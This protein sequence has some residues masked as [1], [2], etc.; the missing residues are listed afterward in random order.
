M[1]N[2][3]DLTKLGERSFEHLANFLAL[4]VL[5]AGHTGFGPGADGGRDGFFEGEAAYPSDVNRW[6]GRWYI[7]SKYHR[8][9]LSKD[10]QKW[11]LAKIKEEID[12]FENPRTKRSW[13]DNW[14]IVTNI[15]PSGTPETG[16]FDKA[17][18]LV[19][20]S[21]N[22]LAERFHIWGG[23]KVIQLLVLH[24]EV[25]D[26]YSHFLTPGHV[27]TRLY[28][29]L[30][31]V[32]ASTRSI[33]RHF[34]VTNFNEQQFTKLEQAGSTIDTRPGIHRLFTDLPF[35]CRQA[36]VQ[37][38]SLEYL[39][40]AA[41]QNHR[42]ESRISDLPLWLPWRKNPR[43]ARVWFIKGGPGQGKSTLTQYLAQI[44]RACLMLGPDAPLAT[45]QQLETAREIREVATKYDSWPLAPRIPVYVE[46][47]DFAKWFGER[48]SDRPRGIFTFLA[49]RLSA[50]IQQ[51]VHV[52]T[53]KRA[54]SE[55]RWLFVF[56]G[57]DEVPSDVKDNVAGE[58]IAFIDDQLIELGADAFFVCTSRPQGYSGQFSSL[59]AAETELSPLNT[60]QA[61]TC[62]AP[63][64]RIDRDEVE[65]AQNFETLRE[66]LQSPSIAE[67]MTT[68]LQAH[69][70]AVVVRD[71]GRPPDRKWRLFGSTE[72]ALNDILASVAGTDS[73]SWLIEVLADTLLE[74]SESE[75][76]G[77]AYVLCLLVPE[78]HSRL[79]EIE[80]GILAKS[81]EYRGC[82]FQMLAKKPEQYDPDEIL[83]T[84]HLWVGKLIFRTLASPD[85][86]RLDPEGVEAAFVV[87]A[88]LKDEIP[89]AAHSAGIDAALAEFML[90]L[91]INNRSF[92][93]GSDVDFCGAVRFAYSTPN[94]N[95]D[96]S[97]WSDDLGIAISTAPGIF[98]VI[99]ATFAI[100]SGNRSIDSISRLADIST[101][102]RALPDAWSAYLPN[103]ILSPKESSQVLSKPTATSPKLTWDFKP[104]YTTAMMSA[105]NEKSA[106]YK[107]LLRD[108]PKIGLRIFSLAFRR[109]ASPQRSWQAF[110]SYLETAEGAGLLA[111]I[112]PDNTDWL[113]G[114]V[115]LWGL[116]LKICGPSREIRTA[117]LNAASLSSEQHLYGDIHPFILDL[118]DEE[119]LIGPILSA[120]YANRR[121]SHFS[122][123]SPTVHDRVQQY[124]PNLAPLLALAQERNQ[125]KDLQAAASMMC[126]LHPLCPADLGE[127][128]IK[129]ILAGYDPH[130]SHNYL[131][132]AAFALEDPIVENR[133]D[134]IRAMGSLLRM[135]NSDLRGRLSLDSIFEEWR[136]RSRAPVTRLGLSNF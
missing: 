47:K 108:H 106:D 55:A 13:P 111:A 33:I 97:N 68:P 104:G 134:A 100:A 41:A 74:Q 9:H 8:P 26:Y 78:G 71:G 67:I 1:P 7:Q 125:R 21:N 17:R 32:Q 132:L 23:A 59:E 62:A 11:L 31:D 58:I 46:L 51:A 114:A 85:W 124:I 98:S 45:T 136:E 86:Q 121:I 120:L 92:D 96:P 95:L 72:T 27:L 84:P 102:L 122:E 3:Y 15:E 73:T 118:P 89:S 129:N 77:A 127:S 44:Q 93:S 36:N 69:I 103:E 81:P 63:V 20:K 14:I 113:R 66:A 107:Q 24:S 123:K 18:E 101:F 56:D 43:R 42:A 115:N 61:L 52:G 90:P 83:W 12:E 37:G 38:M 57:L 133:A 64:L 5:G 30:N 65:S 80:N 130:G 39:V 116:I 91:M 19:A 50:R 128:L 119:R 48:D 75:S 28:R 54:F 53:L 131:Q 60:M 105:G 135:G 34:V 76:I 79:Q 16:A 117:F 126:L 25:A 2:S 82:L 6:S 94:S 29:Q 49:D 87:A 35:R 109:G 110:R 112:I 70:M 10:P 40:Q 88:L 4:R 99:Q 22:A